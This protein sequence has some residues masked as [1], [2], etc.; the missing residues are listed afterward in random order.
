M[1]RDHSNGAGGIH[2]ALS[3]ERIGSDGT[4]VISR[5]LKGRLYGSRI[6]PQAWN[7]QG[8]SSG[9]VG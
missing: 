9:D 6:S 5:A 4:Q 3:I 8:G 1:L 7:Q 2:P